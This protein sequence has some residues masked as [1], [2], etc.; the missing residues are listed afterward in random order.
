MESLASTQL[1]DQAVALVERGETSKAERLVR[2]LIASGARLPKA[3]MVL[4]VLCGE[5]GDRSQ[6]RLWFQEA[7]RCAMGSGE[8]PALRLILNQAVDCLEQGEFDQAVAF[9]VEALAL[10]PMELDAH[11]HQA[12]LC[13]TLGRTDEAGTHLEQGRE[14]LDRQDDNDSETLKGLKALAQTEHYLKR[15]DDSLSSYTN[16]VE[17]DP[18]DV[19][20]LLGLS[21]ILIDSGRSDEAMPWLLQA[22]ALAPDDPD[23]LHSNGLALSHLG[24]KQAAVDLLR[25]ALETH[26][27]HLKSSLLL[28]GCLIDQGFAIEAQAIYQEILKKYPKNYACRIGLATTLRTLADVEGAIEILGALSEDY[29]FDY[30]LFSIWMFTAAL[31]PSVPASD[32]LRK[33]RRFWDDF[34]VRHH[35]AAASSLSF[36][37]A[38][39]L[40]PSRPLRVGLLSG[41]IGNHVV[42]RFLDPLLRHHDSRIC[43]LELISMRRLYDQ[44]SE[45][46]V[47][48][49][50]GSQ[51]LVGLSMD[52]ARTLMRRQ[53]YDLIIDTSGYTNGSGL[54]LLAERCAPVQAH[55]IGYHATTGLPTMDAFIGDRETAAADLQDQFSETL[56]RLPR[57][58]LA[59][60]QTMEFPQATSLM[61][62]SR[63]ILGAF[64]QASKLSDT[65]L[66]FWSEALR[67]VPDAMLLLKSRELQDPAIRQRLE[68]RLSLLG[69]S[70]GRL[71]FVAP[72]GSWHDHVYHYNYLDVA[73]DTTPWSSATTGFEALSMGVPLVAI[74]G[75][76][77]ASR[78]SSSLV[79]GLQQ[80]RWIAQK[81]EDF[82]DIVE[83]LC[84]DLVVLREERSKRQRAVFQ[85]LLFDG[86]DLAEKL[87]DLFGELVASRT[88][89]TSTVLR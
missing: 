42:G 6:R 18:T 22:L 83:S 3:C 12:R 74:R 13:F 40:T 51:S 86:A 87:T 69:V 36:L 76:T 56:W 5:R 85:S 9:G 24:D 52:E 2:H 4:G 25:K 62:T 67:R 29:P 68:E 50:D 65:T 31:A 27:N 81:P 10:Y 46:L 20:S 80:D 37:S 78:M 72:L 64:S 21:G 70:P 79:K 41:D 53:S 7:R 28:A 84:N 55:Y 88:T 54:P 8:P 45:N 15:L 23:V 59:F 11:L 14:L 77:M 71:I 75:N 48:L 63:P 61:E 33:A 60:P 16:I 66:L 44:A 43:Q 89:R 26:P 49:A 38:T 1:L 73:L 35:A 39:S 32:V 34:C 82:A 47:E 57:P 30:D 58:W 17:S 19:Q